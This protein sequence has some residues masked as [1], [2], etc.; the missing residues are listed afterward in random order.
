MI[1]N[2]R[3]V[4]MY[5]APKYHIRN[6]KETFE[7][8]NRKRCLDSETT[9]KAVCKKAACKKKAKKDGEEEQVDGAG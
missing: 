9:V 6:L 5:W 4:K 1:D 2:L 8:S 7:Q 3:G